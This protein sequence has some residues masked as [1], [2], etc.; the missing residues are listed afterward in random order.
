MEAPK[1]SFLFHLFAVNLLGLLLPLSFLLLLRLSSALYLPAPPPL[2]LSLI[3]YLNSPLLFLLVISVIVSALLHSLTG[4]SILHTNFPGHVSQPR[5][6]AA[7]IL[8]CTFQVC[9]GVGIEGSLSI[10]LT[11]AIVG[12][13]EGGLWSRILFFLGLHE[14]VVHWTRTVVKPVVDDTVFGE[15]RK[16]RWF[17]TTATT[18]SFSGLWWWRLRDEAE[19]LVVVAERK[20]LMAAEELGPVD[21]LGWCL[22][23]V[24]V[25]VGIAKVVKSV[26][27]FLDKVLFSRKQSK[28]YEVVLEDN[29]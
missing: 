1:P 27:Q 18:L 14:S 22:Y 23:Y 28:S 10:G 6:Y 9:V 29:V 15:S 4:K 17:E 11:D 5:L 26:A 21:I 13:V 16:E 3:L 2:F 19:A 25:A 8:L 12:R 20:W 7:W 24:N